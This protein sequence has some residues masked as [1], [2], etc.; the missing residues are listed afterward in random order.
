MQIDFKTPKLRKLANS[1]KLAL[2]QLGKQS[3][4]KLRVRLDDLDA[5]IS[6]EDMRFLPA[7]RCHEL[8]GNLKGSLAVD[9]HGGGR[10]VFE[11]S[12]NPPPTKE[13]GGLDW[14]AIDAIRITDITDYH[15]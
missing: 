12:N 10:I 5:A 6:L 3:A 4:R 13:D 1:D 15:D 7:A 14:R 8:K 2:K 9:L 11:P